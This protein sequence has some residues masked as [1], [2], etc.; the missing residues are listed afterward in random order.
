MMDFCIYSWKYVQCTH[1]FK[2]VMKYQQQ[3]ILFPDNEI[4]IT[5]KNIKWYWI[6]KATKQWIWNSFIDFGKSGLKNLMNI[7]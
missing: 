4:I 5:I 7:L 6:D 3:I 1:H 2:N